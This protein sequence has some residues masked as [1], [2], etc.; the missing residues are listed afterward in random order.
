MW[1][2]AK[3]IRTPPPNG[4]RGWQQQFSDAAHS[5]L[6]DTESCVWPAAS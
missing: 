4:K 2:G 1:F 5:V 6:S 3:M